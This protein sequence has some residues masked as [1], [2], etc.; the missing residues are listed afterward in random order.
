M[1]VRDAIKYNEVFSFS[2]SSF[3]G[4]INSGF[5]FE[6]EFSKVS[7]GFVCV[8][9]VFNFEVIKE[10]K[11]LRGVSGSLWRRLFVR[12]N[13]NKQRLTFGAVPTHFLGKI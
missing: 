4:K 13:E 6:R 2:V 5:V 3:G 12:K 10:R 8:C 7:Y 11:W 1:K 9:S